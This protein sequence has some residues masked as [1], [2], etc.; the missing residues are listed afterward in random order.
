M[1]VIGNIDRFATQYELDSD[2]GG[3]WMFGK[4]CYWCAGQ[5][6]GDYELGTSLRDVLFQLEN[7]NKR[8]TDRE[9]KRLFRLKPLDAFRLLDA[10]LYGYITLN[11]SD[12]AE[13]ENWA[14]H[15]VIPPVDTFDRWKAFVVG[16][17]ITEKIIFSQTPFHDVHT[18]ELR[19]NEVG[20]II[21]STCSALDEIYQRTTLAGDTG[22]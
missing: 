5:M 15:N 19:H 16:D 9:S 11:N 2:P 3:Q 12:A 17:E 18:F 20:K 7:T 4:F 10:A 1:P 8:V 13:R 22:R 6:I 21:E 14:R